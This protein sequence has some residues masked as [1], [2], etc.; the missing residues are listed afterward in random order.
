M[1]ASVRGLGAMVEV[2]LEHEIDWWRDD[3]ENEVVFGETI[4]IDAAA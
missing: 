3:L 4:L 1:I 2:T